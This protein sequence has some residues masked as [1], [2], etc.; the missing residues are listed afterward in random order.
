MSRNLTASILI[1]LAL[2]VY[3]TVTAGMISDAKAVKAV[4]DQYASAL[5]NATKLVA[6]RDQV[7]KDYKNIS[8]TDRARLDKMIPSTVDNIRL[9]IDLSSVALRHG[10]SLS[11]I[12]ASASSNSSSNVGNPASPNMSLPAGTQ[13]LSSSIAA[14]IAAPVLDT[15]T[16]SFGASAGYNQFISFLQDLEADLRVM[17]LT[18]L[19]IGAGTGDLYSFQVQFQT[20]WLR[21]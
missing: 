18:R 21:E 20:Y 17:D 11:N 9:I 12:K 5:S 4:N 6:V 19:S 10:F 8:D 16:V 13:P 3:F 7:L 1:V 15:V 2:G 14:S